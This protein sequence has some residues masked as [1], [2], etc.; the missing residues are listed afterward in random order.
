MDL[1]VVYDSRLN[2]QASRFINVYVDLA[3]MTIDFHSN[4]TR[5]IPDHSISMNPEL[6]SNWDKVL[7]DQN[8][9][10]PPS[11]RGL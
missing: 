7:T 10:C 9:I 6:P 1:A 5:P 8:L 4:G 3:L 2:S 11:Q